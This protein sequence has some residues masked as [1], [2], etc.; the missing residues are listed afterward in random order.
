MATSV[1]SSVTSSVTPAAVPVD[2]VNVATGS[3]AQERYPGALDASLYTDAGPS[4]PIEGPVAG[5]QGPQPFGAETPA[6]T[7]GGGIIDLSFTSG[8]D[9]PQESFG[10]SQQTQVALS[11][12]GARPPELHADDGSGAVAAAQSVTPAFIGRLVRKV[13]FGQTYNREYADGDTPYNPTSN[14]RQD[15]DQQQWWDPAPGDGGGYA[16]WD[17]P[18]AERAVLQNLA[19]QSTPVTDVPS[20]YGV[21]GDLPDRSQWNSY[22]AEAYM[23][24]AD[25]QVNQPA[26]DSG[27]TSDWVM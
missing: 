11:Y 3:P 25:P 22:P 20:S 4:Y 2:L 7:G 12:P 24:P 6:E 8:T 17:V 1:N 27:Y 16:P 10:D 18:Y 21:Y 9:G 23:A 19:Y 15:M 13:I 14:G 26:P 5:D